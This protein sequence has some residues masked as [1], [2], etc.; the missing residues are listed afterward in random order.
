MHHFRS[1]VKAMDFGSEEDEK[2]KVASTRESSLDAWNPHAVQKDK[3]E[4][5]I[6]YKRGLTL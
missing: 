6:G 3:E 5:E 4:Q 2:S 1:Y